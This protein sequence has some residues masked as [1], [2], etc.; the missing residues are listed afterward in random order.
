[1]LDIDHFKKI[2]D[3]HGYLTGDSVLRALA[4]LLQKRL[5]P[6]DKLGRYGGEEFCAI[7]PETS[8]E[9]AAAIAGELRVLV[10]GTPFRA[11][12]LEINVRSPSARRVA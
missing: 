1:M 8:I 2:N 12:S 10:A 9:N 11:R 7:L 5:R 3:T 6:N 4:S